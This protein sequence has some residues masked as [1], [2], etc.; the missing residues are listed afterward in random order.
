MKTAS[1]LLEVIELEHIERNIFRG[2]SHD[3]GSGR[4]F[5]GQVLSQALHAAM[6]T[7]D[8]SR[9]MHSMHAYFILA[10]DMEAPI[11]YEV[12]RT[13]DGGSFT[14]RRVRAIQHGREIF[15]SSI[16]FHKKEDG[17]D[18]Q[19]DMKEVTPPEELMTDQDILKNFGD[20]MPESLKRL[21]RPR[22]ILFKPTD[23]MSFL[24]D[25]KLPPHQ[26]IW[27]KASGEVPADQR[28]HR[29]ILAYAT[30]YNLLG[31]AIL[32]HR[33][34]VGFRDLMM[35]SL[36]HA[37]WIHDEVH[38]A[39]WL[40]FQLESPWAGAGRGFARGSIFNREGKLLASLAQ[41]GLMRVRRK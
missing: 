3:V 7:V 17:L 26:T 13:R 2:P 33:D 39:D 5:G 34:Q 21:I 11:V 9:F 6:L 20:G 40:L 1:E 23:P 36:D 27:F 15:V 38:I 41:E 37:L 8:Q 31:S 25:E 19:I 10:G 28:I 22:P 24:R 32:P 35:A 18:H 12:D 16:S 14:T 4:V 30:D 29:R